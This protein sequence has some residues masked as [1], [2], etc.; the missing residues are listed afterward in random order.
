MFNIL[1]NLL[2]SLLA[3]LYFRKAAAI[4]L[5]AKETL[6]VQEQHQNRNVVKKNSGFEY[7]SLISVTGNLFFLQT[8]F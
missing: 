2:N 6:V 7:T 1:T 8:S 3:T 4:A 5:T